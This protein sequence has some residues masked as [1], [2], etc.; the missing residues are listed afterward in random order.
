MRAVII[1]ESMYGNTHAIAGA[2]G[3]GLGPEH[4]VRV[5]PVA[6]ATSE[7]LDGADLVVAGAPTHVHGMSRA[8]SRLAA[9]EAAH[10]D[11]SGLT[12]EPHAQ[13]PGLRDWFGTVGRI[14]GCGAAFDTRLTGPAAFTGHASKAIAK[15]LDRQ[16]G[17][18]SGGPAGHRS[19]T[20]GGGGRGAAGGEPGGGPGPGL[21]H[22]AGGQ[23]PART[24]TRGCL[25]GRGPG[26][27][28]RARRRW[29]R[30]AEAWLGNQSG[31]QPRSLPRGSGSRIASPGQ[32]SEESSG[33]G[34]PG[35]QFPA[36]LLGAVFLARH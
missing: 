31:G 18:L 34:Q 20:Q 7:L 8:R 17:A 2:I 28:G 25:S 30:E 32:T 24:G 36:P 5:V 35:R 3:R 27:G 13:G 11:G 1:F 16:R 6:E 4:E 23:R 15:L 14:R 10:K 19:D 22:G 12:L 26:G 9:A 29:L 33:R 21:G